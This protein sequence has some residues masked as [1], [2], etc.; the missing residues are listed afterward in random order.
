[1]RYARSRTMMLLAAGLALAGCAGRDEPPAEDRP[2]AQQQAA[3]PPVAA[4]DTAIAAAPRVA[5]FDPATAPVV[6]PQLGA[7]PYFGLID[8]Y[9]PEG[10][11]FAQDV[12]FDKYEFFD[13]TKIIPVE[14]RLRTIAAEGA[15][16]S[17]H[18]VFK[19]Y[20]SMVKGLGGVTVYEGADPKHLKP[21]GPP[22]GDRRHRHGFT[23]DRA[24]VYMLRT[25]DREVWVEAYFTPL[26]SGKS[27]YFLTVVE[28]TALEA[29]AKLLPAEEMKRELDEKG[30]VALYIE[31]DFDRADIRPDSRPIVDEV[32]K[33]LQG[34]PTLSLVVE[35]HTDDAG[36][37][38]YNKRLSAARANA[39]VAALTARG[40]EARRLTGMGFGQERPIA[41]NTTDAGRAR[42]RRVELVK[43]R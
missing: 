14:G 5:G 39:V 21:R 31:F 27:N 32:L 8:G 29:R 28:K 11:R 4:A 19:T 40:I 42:N 9:T 12:A 30:H 2:L 16:A 24:G 23:A 35:G 34:N 10:S 6:S 36:T 1:M 41:D 7:F 17:A 3:A 18:E 43:A 20:E 25:P 13:G 15:G 26:N 37:P 38:E 33:L 22:Y